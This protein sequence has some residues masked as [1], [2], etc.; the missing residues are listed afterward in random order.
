MTRTNKILLLVFGAIIL[1]FIVNFLQDKTNKKI[2]QSSSSQS[3][4]VTNSQKDK[5]ASQENEGGNVTITVKPK[6]LKVGEKP[7]F[8]VEFNT[9]SVDLTFDISL[10]SSLIDDKG[11]ILTTPKWDG[12]A[13]GGHHRSG[14]LSFKT[15]LPRTKYVELVI[16]DVA[17]VKERRFK[18]NL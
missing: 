14:T 12:S 15:P 10:V 17:G 16:Y 7:L 2:K 1:F 4:A 5:F 18:W 9:H 3:S 11:N 8:E 6:I 13:P